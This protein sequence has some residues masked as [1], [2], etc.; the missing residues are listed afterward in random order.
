MESIAME[1]LKN[2]LSEEYTAKEYLQKTLEICSAY[3]KTLEQE[4]DFLRRKGS[5]KQLADEMV[6]I[7]YF[8][9]H[10]FT[11]NPELIKI[12]LILGNQQYDA[13]VHDSRILSSGINFLEISCIEDRTEHDSR[14]ELL[15]QDKSSISHTTREIFEMIN[16]IIR[17]KSSK[18]YPK[19]TALLIYS[20]IAFPRELYE[21][22]EFEHAFE[23]RERL[24][25][26]HS[27]FILDRNQLYQL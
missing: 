9:K 14:V 6:P 13:E 11:Q 16:N 3:R 10:F 24:K 26:F 23:F 12:R 15:S 19:N 2:I 27:A 1:V 4:E 8:C 25:N 20:K 5:L 7:G 17:K 22:F 18:N 21:L